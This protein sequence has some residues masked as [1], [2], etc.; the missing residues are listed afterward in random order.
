MKKT[1]ITIFII[2]LILQM[3]CDPSCKYTPIETAKYPK[4]PIYNIDVY[5]P[6]DD[7]PLNVK[8]LGSLRIGENGLTDGCNRY[9]DVIILAR[10][11]AIEVGGDVIQI[12]EVKPPDM[13]SSCYR[14]RADIYESQT[15]D[16]WPSVSQTE[17]EF[18]DYLDSHRDSLKH[19]EGIWS[20]NESG[21]WKNITTKSTGDLPQ[22]KPCRI[23]IIKDSLYSD[24]DY[25]AVIIESEN[26]HWKPGFIKA[27]F[28]DTAD[29]K[30]FEGLW[31]LADFSIRRRNYKI[32][33]DGVMIDEMTLYRDNFEINRIMT[34]VKDYPQFK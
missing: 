34:L 4:P 25:I 17:T 11:K 32:N 19:I 28:R 33:E 16:N 2:S 3:D 20:V 18:R 30:V 6:T 13:L 26:S 21:T 24:Y 31:Y 5:G 14:I 1:V 8:L 29:D 15:P 23:A 27:K 10:E 7:L 12:T 9:E 22:L